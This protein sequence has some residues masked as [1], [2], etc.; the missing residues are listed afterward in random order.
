MARFPCPFYASTVSASVNQGT[1]FN[2]N[3]TSWRSYYGFKIELKN[4]IFNDSMFNDSGK[5]KAEAILVDNRNYSLGIGINNNWKF[6]IG[7]D[8]K[9]R[10]QYWFYDA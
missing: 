9:L 2:P 8:N 4:V 3:G 5:L 7:T 1:L 10:F 6:Y